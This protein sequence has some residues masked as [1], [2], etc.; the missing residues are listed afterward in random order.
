MNFLNPVF[1][2]DATQAPLTKAANLAVKKLVDGKFKDKSVE[3]SLVDG[4]L[5]VRRLRPNKQLLAAKKSKDSEWKSIG[6]PNIDAK[7]DL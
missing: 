6:I 5:T 1:G 7:K 3:I 2:S 4:V